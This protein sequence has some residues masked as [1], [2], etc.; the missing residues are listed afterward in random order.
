MVHVYKLVISVNPWQEVQVC[1]YMGR[2]HLH[3]NNLKG[4]EQSLR[5]KLDTF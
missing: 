4:D 1:L 5:S 3:D 2:H